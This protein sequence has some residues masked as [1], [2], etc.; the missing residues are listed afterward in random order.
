MLLKA[1]NKS[2]RVIDDSD[3][4]GMFGIDMDEKEKQVKKKN[5][6]NYLVDRRKDKK[7]KTRFLIF[8]VRGLSLLYNP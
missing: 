2:S 3:V 4:S 8:L 1:K 7:K 6:S 5:G